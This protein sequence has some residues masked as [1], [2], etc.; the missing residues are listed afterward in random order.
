MTSPK[1]R[2]HLLSEEDLFCITNQGAPTDI[3]PDLIQV[4]G[5]GQLI[6]TM[7]GIQFYRHAIAQYGVDLQLHTIRTEEDVFHMHVDLCA[8][9]FSHLVAQF[10]REGLNTHDGRKLVEDL[11]KD[12]LDAIARA[13]N[14]LK[15]RTVA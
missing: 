7:R 3:R 11:V 10:D 12:S 13:A 4:S 9:A 6:F 2:I 5:N 1:P 8:A 15:S 14:K